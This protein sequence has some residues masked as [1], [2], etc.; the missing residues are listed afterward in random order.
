MKDSLSSLLIAYLLVLPSAQEAFCKPTPTPVAKKPELV[1]RTKQQDLELRDWISG[2]MAEAQKAKAEVQAAQNSNTDLQD[3]LAAATADAQN[4]ANEC[5]KDKE[6]AKHPFSC[7][8]HRLLKHLLWVGLGL[9][10]VV[11]VLL[12]ASFLVPGLAPLLGFFLSIWNK[13][14]SLF[15]PKP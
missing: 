6:C 11:V 12:V 10:G 3:K 5:A 1:C 2:I 7:G 9:L 15:K 4:L 14:L 13:I 8:F